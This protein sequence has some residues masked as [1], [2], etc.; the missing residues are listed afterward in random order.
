MG[1]P[2]DNFFN[3]ITKHIDQQEVDIWFNMNNIL[4]EK[5]EYRRLGWIGCTP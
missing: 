5:M 2:M 1:E 3:Y 4:P